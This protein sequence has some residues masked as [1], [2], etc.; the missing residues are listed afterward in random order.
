MNKRL[1]RKRTKRRNVSKEKV[2]EHGTGGKQR[3][4]QDKERGLE[5]RNVRVWTRILHQPITR[6]K[7]KK[8]V[9]RTGK[10]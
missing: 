8:G 2:H 6:R 9:R 4:K 10:G 7:Y 1:G 5:G 3:E